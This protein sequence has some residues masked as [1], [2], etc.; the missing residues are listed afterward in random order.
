LA[1]I[2]IGEV[3]NRVIASL[4]DVDEVKLLAFMTLERL[5]VVA[6]AT[7]VSRLDELAEGIESIVNS[8]EPKDASGQDI[9]RRVCLSLT[10][11]LRDSYAYIHYFTGGGTDHHDSGA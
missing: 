1:Q 10:W 4:K 11:T 2:D 9:Q 6:E 5:T 8:V 3:L 7:V